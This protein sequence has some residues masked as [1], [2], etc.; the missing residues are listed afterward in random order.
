MNV[1]DFKLWFVKKETLH[2]LEHKPPYFNER[3]IW[4]CSVGE[5]IG[6]EI[7]G[8]NDYFRRPVLI[9]KKLSKYSFIGVPL[10]TKEK[11]GSWYVEITHNN[12][13]NIVVVSQI[14][15]LDYR[16]LDKKMATLDT[17]NFDN[18]ATAIH[19]LLFYKK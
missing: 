16:R 7:N 5:N 19:N 10:T 8:K 12:Q 15:N 18:V 1:K 17:V 13:K 6:N 9:I 4:W 11:S 3:E 2:S 14:R